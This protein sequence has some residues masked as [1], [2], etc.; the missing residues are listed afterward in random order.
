MRMAMD[1]L[2]IFKMLTENLKGK[3]IVYENSLHFN[4]GTDNRK[5]E[6]NSNNGFFLLREK[7][8]RFFAEISADRDFLLKDST[9]D[10]LEFNSEKDVFY[11]G[12]F[13]ASVNNSRKLIEALPN[14]KPSRMNKKTSVGFGDRIGIA[15]GAH[16]KIS[17]EYDYF[18]LF[19]Q[20]S[21]REISKTS[22][23]CETVIHNAVMGVFQEGYADKW[24][25]D[26]DHVGDEKWLNIMLNN[27]YL[28][29]TMFTIDTYNYINLDGTAPDSYLDDVKFKERLLKSKKYIGK[30]FNS[31]GCNLSFNEDNIH[32]IVSRY[33]K[34]L[35]FL[36]NCFNSIKSRIKEFDFEPTFDE[37]DIDTTPLEHFYI[38]SELINDGVSFTTM[39]PKF[40]GLFEKGI[41]YAGDLKV[42]AETL[43]NHNAVA[44]HFGSYR[45]SLHSADDKFGVFKYLREVLGDNFHVKTSGTTWMES[46]RTIAKFSPGLFKRILDSVLEKAEENSRSYYITLDYKKI[47][48]Y[49]KQKQFTD[50]IDIKETRQLLHVSYGT[51]INGFRNEILETLFNHEEAYMDN[52]IKNYKNHFKS[53]FGY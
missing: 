48:D 20:Q 36:S 46:L 9:A 17:K 1:F 8:K 47:N 30:S 13:D 27:T 32:F 50:L 40:P 19:A 37:R 45:L 25:S 42:F 39:A 10:V 34:S 3:Y 52:I 43:K 31:A 6:K 53:I 28:P 7:N 12:L 4:N 29:Y 24:G 15:S 5:A 38:S 35:D 49:F 2:N 14:L 41:D 18:P 16:V 26:A 11:L 23:D 51:V 22:K 21:G 44:K 33:Y